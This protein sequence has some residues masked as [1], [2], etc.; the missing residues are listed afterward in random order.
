MRL[1]T[2][3]VDEWHIQLK[4]R[5]FYVI[6]DLCTGVIIEFPDR[7]KFSGIQGEVLF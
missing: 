3:F 4:I 1:D 6:F 2:V 7:E 5:H